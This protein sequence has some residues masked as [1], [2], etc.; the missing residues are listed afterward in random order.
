M[1]RKPLWAFC[2]LLLVASMALAACGGG[3]TP[4]QAP[5]EMV[6]IRWRTRPDN[7]AEQDVYQKISDDLSAKLALQG[8]KLQY[9]PAPVTGYEDKLKA[10]FSAG[11]APDIV[12]IPGASTADYASLG[13]I[14]LD[15]MPL[16]SA[17]SCFQAHRLLRC[18]HEGA[19][20]R[21]PPVGSPTGYL[22]LGHLLQ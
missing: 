10:E 9:D 11:T 21:G 7:Q 5:A 6:T 4:T 13:V 16:A 14:M 20:K 18:A 15:L 8:I 1:N 19:G 22:Y 12:W 3:A 2:S 17:D